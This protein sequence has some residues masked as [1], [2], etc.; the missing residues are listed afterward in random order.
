MTDPFDTFLAAVLLS[1]AYVIVSML[2]GYFLAEQFGFHFWPATAG[3]FYLI[4][5]FKALQP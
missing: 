5:L 2:G 4:A 3:C 1:M